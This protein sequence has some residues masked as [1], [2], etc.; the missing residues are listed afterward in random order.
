MR[1]DIDKDTS[2]VSTSQID[3]ARINDTDDCFPILVAEDSPIFRLLL[4]KTLRKAGHE[5]TSVEN[6]RKAF[7]LFERHFFP[8][9]L[10]DWMMPEMDGIELCK[11]VRSTQ[12]PS[13]VFIIFLTSKNAKEDIVTGLEAGADDYLSKPFNPDELKARIK[14]GIRILKLER[15]LIK[16][17]EEI[18]ML[19]FTDPLTGCFN[20]GYADNGLRKEV[21]RALRYKS[22]LSVVMFDIDRF[23]SIND[24]YGH[25]GG[26]S[27]LVEVVN[28]VRRSIRNDVDWLC[29][30]GGDEFVLVLPE[31]DIAGAKK[32]SE[33]IRTKISQ[34]KIT[35]ENFEIDVTASFG[36]ADLDPRTEH[37]A[38]FEILVSQ[39]DRLLYQAKK[40]G[41][42][43]IEVGSVANSIKTVQSGGERWT[44]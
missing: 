6:G 40:N 15:S 16:A 26:D 25:Q 32:L 37:D 30:Y 11:A 5:V 1:V 43:R 2:L 28:R 35:F 9:I 36:V 29:R 27:V 44:F 31:T 10:S 4:E 7:D 20:R 24:S 42:N 19:S 34:E 39:A 17:K 22:P 13:Y 8:I 12:S 3:R 14:T 41:K 38:T 33:R 23:K 21:K 18:R